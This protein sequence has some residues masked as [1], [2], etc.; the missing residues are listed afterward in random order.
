MSAELVQALKD[1][2]NVCLERIDM[3]KNMINDETVASVL[4]MLNPVTSIKQ[5]TA[6]TC[7]FLR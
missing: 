6:K 4:T 5:V 1:N 3:S 7:I 2:K